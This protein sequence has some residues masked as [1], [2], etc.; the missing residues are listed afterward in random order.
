MHRSAFV[1]RS[2]STCISKTIALRQFAGWLD[3]RDFDR[4]D[5]G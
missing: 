2:T 5:L 4:I 3:Y 1:D